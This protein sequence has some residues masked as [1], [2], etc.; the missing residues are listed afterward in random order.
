MD[1]MKADWWLVPF[2]EYAK[3]LR[4]FARLTVQEVAAEAIKPTV[5]AAQTMKTEGDRLLQALPEDGFVIALERTG[6]PLSSEALAELMRSEG[7]GG[8]PL[9][10]VVGGAAGLDPAVLQRANKKVT[11]SAMTF[12]HEMAR[13]ILAEQLYR[14]VT[15]LAGKTY[16]Y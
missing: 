13:V 10:F 2:E 7:E 12:T 5:V 4:P 15:I 1:K 8:R 11:L 14:A 16:H 9:V 6:S 3:R